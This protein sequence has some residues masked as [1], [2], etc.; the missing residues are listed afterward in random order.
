MLAARLTQN[1]HSVSTG[2]PKAKLRIALVGLGFGMEFIP[3]YLHHPDVA[4]LILCDSNR[5]VLDAAGDKFEVGGR[6]TDLQS[7]LNSD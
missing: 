7:I 1:E 5:A 4:S 6:T 2:H 3:I